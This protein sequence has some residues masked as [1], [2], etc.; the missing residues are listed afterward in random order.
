MPPLASPPA[1]PKQRAL[2]GT[3]RIFLAESL[4]IP[5]GLLTAAYLARRLGPDGYGLFTVATALVAWIEWSLTALFARAAVKFVA[6]ASDWR[7]IGSTIL[8]VQLLVSG[9]VALLLCLSAPL[10]A[11]ALGMP[12]LTPYLRIYAV[13]I[14]LFTLA[15]AHRSI[16]IGLGNFTE[17]AYSAAARWTSRFAI[18]VLLVELGWSVQGAIL[19]SIGASVIELVVARVFVRPTFSPRALLR[20]R[21]LMSYAAPLLLGALALRLFDKLDVIMLTAL[22]GDAQQAG[23]YGAAQNLSILPGLFSLACSHLLLA[24]LSRAFRDGEAARARAISREALRG[25][26]LLIPL[27]AVVAGSAS[28]IVALVFGAAF[29]SAGPLLAWLL[30][31]AVALVFVSVGTAVLTAA[32]RPRLTLAMTVPLP[33]LAMVGYLVLIPRQG[34]VG[35]AAVTSLCAV[36]GAA[37]SVIAVYRVCGTAPPRA[38]TAR[39][40]L[41]ALGAYAAAALWVTPGWLLVLKLPVL[42]LA[43][44]LALAMLG[45]FTGMELAMARSVIRRDTA[46]A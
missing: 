44:I 36:L 42:G 9:T 24:T 15:Q 37:V 14:P 26:L 46:A 34:P 2:A 35:A 39:A 6:D 12:E 3:V 19:G 20:V 29:R 38:T 4:I 43:V 18:I 5:S 11:A 23:L 27:A 40:A 17:R 7:P 30:L 25:L 21:E 33:L 16:L 1:P 31:G 22:G 10:V 41:V 13:D 8:S 45:E 28:E 32:G